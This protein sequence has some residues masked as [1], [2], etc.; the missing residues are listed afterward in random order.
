MGVEKHHVIPLSIGGMDIPE[1]ILKISTE[2]HKKIHQTLNI[3][4]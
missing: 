1:N 4:Y 2:N 3:P